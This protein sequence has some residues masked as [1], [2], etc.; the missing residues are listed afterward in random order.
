M[1]S[2][3]RLLKN[4]M[5]LYGTELICGTGVSGFQIFELVFFKLLS[6]WRHF[7]SR[8]N[9]LRSNW[10]V[11]NVSSLMADLEIQNLHSK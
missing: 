4:A 10:S 1:T 11:L 5:R 3:T 6:K 7:F 9:P 2:K 8:F